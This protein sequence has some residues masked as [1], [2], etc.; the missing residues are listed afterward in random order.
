MKLSPESISHGAI[1]RTSY[2]R[3][4]FIDIVNYTLSRYIDEQCHNLFILNGIVRHYLTIS[5]TP[6]DKY[7]LLPTGDGVC[8][9]LVDVLEPYDLDACL[10]VEILCGID[11]VNRIN[12]PDK[13]KL[14]VRIGISENVDNVILDINNRPNVI[15]HG[16]NMAQRM[17]S[18]TQPMSISLSENVFE[19]LKQRDRY[20][21]WL[22][23][24]DA[25]VRHGSKIKCY[26][27][28]HPR[29]LPLDQDY[30]ET[31]PQSSSHS[32]SS[33][34]G[35]NPNIKSPNKTN[36]TLLFGENKSQSSDKNHPKN[37]PSHSFKVI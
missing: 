31:A 20:S 24:Y 11:Q 22:K 28:C 7:L 26:Q 16:I 29:F 19:R 25:I 1:L 18:V 15:G 35:Q 30:L 13:N 21:D 36:K 33:P 17:M 5:G 4:I 23:P 8:I 14:K 34:A 6:E 10:A 12:D 2:I 3:Y 27:L 32:Q 37:K 9:A